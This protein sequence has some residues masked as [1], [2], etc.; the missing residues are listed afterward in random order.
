MESHQVCLGSEPGCGCSDGRPTRVLCKP[1][2]KRR[3][4]A[5]IDN[6][7]LGQ[8]IAR[9]DGT[10]AAKAPDEQTYPGFVGQAAALRVLLELRR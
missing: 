2:G 1:A 4:S 10:W 9:V 8:V 6:Q 5:W 7:F 3:Y